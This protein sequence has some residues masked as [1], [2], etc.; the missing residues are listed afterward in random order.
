MIQD[1]AERFACVTGPDLEMSMDK[2]EARIALV[3][4]SNLGMSLDK[5]KARALSLR[6]GIVRRTSFVQD[7]FC[8]DGLAE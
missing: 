5:A 7:N 1:V 4:R 2:A 6:C 3:G 8:I